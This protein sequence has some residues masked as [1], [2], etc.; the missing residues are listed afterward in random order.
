MARNNVLQY[1]FKLSG[2]DVSVLV[3]EVSYFAMNVQRSVMQAQLIARHAN[4]YELYWGLK[5]FLN[6]YQLV[7]PNGQSVFVK[8]VFVKFLFQ[9]LV[10]NIVEMPRVLGFVFREAHRNLQ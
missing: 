4:F 7:D 8:Y 1:A 2:I 10:K 6:R 3:H 9:A 5:W